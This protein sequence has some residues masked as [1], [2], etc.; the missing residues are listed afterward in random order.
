MHKTLNIHIKETTGVLYNRQSKYKSKIEEN[1]HNYNNNNLEFENYKK[2]S[3]S[4][5]YL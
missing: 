5:F 3:G 4:Y 1:N 2:I